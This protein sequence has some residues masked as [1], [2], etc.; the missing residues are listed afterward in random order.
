M[1]LGGLGEIGM[2]AYLYGL[3]PADA[4]QWLMVDLGVTFPGELEPGVD[5]VLPD[6][7]FLEAE[8]AALAGIVLTHAHEDHIGAVIDLWPRLR[9][10][11]Y[12]SPFTAAMLRS[13]LTERGNTLQLPIVEVKLG[14]RFTVGPFDIELVSMAHS[15]PETS[16]LA[17]RTPHGLVFHSSDWKLDPTPPLGGGT[18]EAKLMALGEEGVA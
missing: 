15:I 10:K 6:L 5:V 18:D 17:L 11:L 16:A 2:N 8:R 13:K 12:A 14:S 9:A 1:A 3:G 7:R 4:R